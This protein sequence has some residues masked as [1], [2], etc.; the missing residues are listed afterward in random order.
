MARS[1]PAGFTL[2]G[3]PEAA[4]WELGQKEWQ[5]SG[6]FESEVLRQGV[7]VAASSHSGLIPLQLCSP[8]RALSGLCRSSSRSAL[9]PA[10]PVQSSASPPPP[11]GNVPDS[12]DGL[13]R[14]R[15]LLAP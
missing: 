11:S 10:T 9:S 15:G 6:R 4:V 1:P 12:P 7:T 13:L 14:L 3:L 2:R 5:V 8:T